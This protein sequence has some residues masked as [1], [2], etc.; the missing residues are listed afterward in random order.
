MLEVDVDH[1]LVFVQFDEHPDF[2]CV[3][4]KR[5]LQCAVVVL[6]EVVWSD[7]SRQIEPNS[8]DQNPPL[9]E[10]DHFGQ[11]EPNST[12]QN[13]PLTESDHSG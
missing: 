9:T 1:L 8:T 6:R 4:A 3:L 10:S 13:P 12:D 2:A 11:I 7:H 5:L